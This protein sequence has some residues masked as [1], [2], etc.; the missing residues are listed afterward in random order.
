VNT[1]SEVSEFDEW[2]A[3]LITYAQQRMQH[4]QAV[5]LQ[6]CKVCDADAEL[7]DVLDFSR[8][9]DAQP[10]CPPASGI[11]VCYRRCTRCRFIGTNFFDDFTAHQWTS[12]IYNKHYYANVDPEYSHV[13]PRANAAVVD[14]LLCDL[15]SDWRGLDYGGGNGE[16]ARHLQAMGY[17]YDCH[18]PFGTST[19]PESSRGSY[20]FCTAF[21]VAEHTPDPRAFIA[22][23]VRWCSPGRVAVLIG[24]HVHDDAVS[25]TS[26]LAWWYAAPRNG[27]VSLYSR[28]SLQVLATQHG[29][30]CLSLSEQTH[31]L[32]RGYTPSEARWF[33]LRGKLRGRLRRLL[34]RQVLA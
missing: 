7:F 15:K 18:D 1:A 33:L 16:T 34:R 4:E 24:T 26:R 17:Q 12:W 14:A 5:R 22:D 30:G 2:P 11:P 28:Q 3:E 9:C 8:T 6:A 21:E 20:N 10:G 32:T 27:H 23:V 13:R 25:D 19:A 31:L 29:L